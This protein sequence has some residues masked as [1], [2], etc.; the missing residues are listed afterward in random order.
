MCI[1]APD[2][3]TISFSSGLIL[4]GAGGHRSSEG[5]K[6]VDLCFSFS[7]RIFLASLHAASRAFRSCHS[8]SLPETDPQVLEHWCYAE[9]D[10]LGKLLQAM[11]FGPECWRDAKRL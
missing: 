10:H 11:V 4:D 2:S 9:E 3:T 5:E 6:K 8:V 1:D 7:F